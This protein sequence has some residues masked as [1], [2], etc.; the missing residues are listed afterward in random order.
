M[1]SMAS[2]LRPAA[3]LLAIFVGLTGILY[4]LAMT[5]IGQSLFR[6]QANGSLVLRNGRAVG[7]SLIGQAFAGEGYLH[8]RPSAAA[9]GYDASASS[10]SNLAPTSAKLFERLKADAAAM[11]E[12]TGA[13]TLPADAITA[14]GSGLDPDVSPAFAA[15]QV[16]RIAKARRVPEDLVRRAIAGST[17]GRTLG[18]LGEP[19]VNVLAT[20]LALDAAAP[21]RPSAAPAPQPGEPSASAASPAG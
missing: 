3:V 8:P 19:R 17:A 5:G 20:N 7:S 4:P 14:S 11:K 1:N 9:G 12:A 21:S 6:V 16:P 15:L 13:A 2:H 18:I 10:G